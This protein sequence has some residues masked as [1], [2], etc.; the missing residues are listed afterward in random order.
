MSKQPQVVNLFSYADDRG[1]LCPVWN[2]WSEDTEKNLLSNFAGVDLHDVKRVYFI[3]NSQKDVVRGFHYHKA[4]TKYFVLLQGMAKFITAKL[5]D[6]DVDYLQSLK[7][8]NAEGEYDLDTRVLSHRQQQM[9][10]V[11]P[12]YANG[13]M[14]LTDDCS[15]LALSSSTFEMSKNDDRRIPP[16]IFGNVWKVKA[17]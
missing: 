13:W 9:L 17:R 12:G 11:P 4:E 7:D 1:I 15:L 14:S 16:D 10:I 3:Q 6:C 2:N 5:A 8:S